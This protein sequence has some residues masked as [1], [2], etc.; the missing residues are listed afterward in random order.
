VTDQPDQRLSRREYA[1][2]LRCQKYGVVY[3]KVNRAKAFRDSGWVCGLCQEPVDSRL[4]YPNPMSASLDHIVPL[5]MGPEGSPGHVQSNCQ[6]THL[7]CNVR[8]GSK[9]K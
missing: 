4:R 8:A 9:R 7:R 6:L 3:T 1:I 2:W 5:V